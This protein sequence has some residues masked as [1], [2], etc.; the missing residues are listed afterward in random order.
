MA[1]TPGLSWVREA[2]SQVPRPRAYLPEPISA[3]FLPKSTPEQWEMYSCVLCLMNPSCPV[4]AARLVAHLLM[5][6][7]CPPSCLPPLTVLS[8]HILP[9]FRLSL[10]CH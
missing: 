7:L 10:S 4:A 3:L 5:G 6:L 1:Q 8:L 2:V 9:W